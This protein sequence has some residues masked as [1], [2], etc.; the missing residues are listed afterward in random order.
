MRTYRESEAEVPPGLP[1]GWAQIAAARELVPRDIGELPYGSGDLITR[2]LW[3]VR[4]GEW[5]IYTRACLPIDDRLDMGDPENVRTICELMGGLIHPPS[6]HDDEVSYVILRRPATPDPSPAD[7]H[8][9]RLIRE[10]TAEHATGSW[11]FFTAGP[12]GARELEF[13]KYEANE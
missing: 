4:V 6:C 1:L 13:P 2:S 9:F 5:G 7:E 12:D 3:L 8:I 11:T 10:A